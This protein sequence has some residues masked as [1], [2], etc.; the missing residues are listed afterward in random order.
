MKLNKILSSALCFVLLFGCIVA[1]FP[2]TSLAANS[3]GVT[4]NVKTD[5]ENAKNADKVKAVLETYVKYGVGKLDFK[6]ADEMLAY[7]QE[8]G[9]IDSAT[10]GN[11]SLYINRY[12]GVVYYRNNLSGQILTSN[13]IDPAYQSKDENNI[14]SI[15]NKNT[16]TLSQLEISYFQVTNTTNGGVYNSFDW[17]N[18]GSLLTVSEIENGIRV[19]YILGE[20]V[21]AFVAPGALI[22]EDFKAHLSGPLFAKLV[23]LMEDY[24]GEFSSATASSL[25]QRVRDYNRKQH[26]LSSYN[27]DELP[28]FYANGEYF[29]NGI[30]DALKAI[31]EYADVTLGGKNKTTE[32]KARYNEIVKF[33]DNIQTVLGMYDPIVYAEE[34]NNEESFKLWKDKVPALKDGHN[35]YFMRDPSLVNLRL[36]NRALTQSLPEYT[37]ADAEADMEKAQFTG[38]VVNVPSF[39]ISVNYTLDESG[40]LVVSIPTNSI[41]FDEEVF[42]ISSISPLKY[43]GS[44]DMGQDGYIFFPD[45]SGTVVEFA[46]FYSNSEINKINTNMFTTSK[47]YGNDYCYSNI[48]GAHRELVSMPVF[49]MVSTVNATETTKTLLGGEQTKV[50]NGFFAIIEEGASLASVNLSSDA[51]SHKYAYTYASFNPFPSDAIDLS[52]SLSVSNLGSYNMCAEGHYEGNINMRMVMLEDPDVGQKLHSTGAVSEYYPA[53]YVGMATYYRNYLVSRGVL[54]PLTDTTKDLPLYIEALGSVDVTKKIL[55][56]PVTVSEP[57]TTFEDI[58]R[59]YAEL[60][61]AINHLNKKA[62]DYRA[63][64][65]ELDPKEVNLIADYTAKAAKLEALATRIVDIKNV[66]FRLTGFANGG[67]YYKYPAKVKWESAVGGKRGFKTLIENAKSISADPEKNFGVYPDFDFVYITNMGSFDGISKNRDAAKLVDNRYATQQVY[68]SI[69][70]EF[71]GFFTLLASTDSFDRLYSKFAKKYGKYEIDNLSV[72]TLGSD[73]NSNFDKDNFISREDSLKNVSALLKRMAED[74]GYSLMVDAGNSYT[75]A[76]ADHILSISTDSSHFKF[77]SF[78]VPFVGMVLHG[79]VNYTGSALNYSGSPEYDILRSIENGANLYYIL[80]CQNTNYLKEDIELSDYYGV[81]YNNWYEKI[82]DQ[83]AVLN[84]AIG[85]LQEYNITNHMVIYAER[86]IDS[87]ELES[88]RATLAAEYISEIEANLSKAIDRKIKEIRNELAP[89]EVSK[90]IVLDVDFDAIH[91]GLAEVVDVELDD[92]L[93]AKY[94]GALDEMIEGYENRYNSDDAG[95]A[96]LSFGSAADLAYDSLYSYNTDSVATDTKNYVYTD[97]TCDNGNV[98]MVTYTKTVNG[99]VV[100]T[101]NFILNYN[102]FAVEVIVAAGEEPI[103]LNAYG[104]E[105]IR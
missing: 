20:A 56:F 17:I 81:D 38:G 66:N 87:N 75:L 84:K 82:V 100:D 93:L 88:N 12:T 30:S 19:N 91:N 22:A 6:T 55:T 57:L 52:Q 11:Y 96:V 72:S 73:L 95:A 29:S 8:Q 50:T 26:V 14:I 64:A 7:E 28:V 94:L 69:S 102:N 3:E 59:M 37:V 2:V 41:I 46:D 1:A 23:A 10:N 85:G 47:V 16:P 42:S 74:D 61:D 97:F 65:A 78:A 89:G 103:T 48:T 24:C 31:K 68:N 83:Y 49:G 43:F 79:Y 54:S 98:V 4:V 63:Q 15:G 21:D 71:E 53:S 27:V 58:E 90:G 76:Y 67:M 33:C 13:P 51:S 34:K 44:G 104:Y 45:G 62:A 32:N 35:V 105:V 80:C 92:E 70:Q 101:V 86:I 5:D 60:S 40:A 25:M 18:Q 77:S 39:K 36:V 99:E 9:Y